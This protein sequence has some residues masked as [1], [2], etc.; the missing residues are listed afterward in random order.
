MIKTILRFLLVAYCPLLWAQHQTATLTEPH[1]NGMI[2]YEVAIREISLA[3]AALPTIHSFATGEVEGEWVILAGRTSGLHGMTGNNGFNPL[4]ENRDVWVINPETKQSWKKSLED[5]TASGLSQDEVDSLSCTNTEFYQDGETMI[6]VGGYGYMRSAAD[7]VTYDRISAINLP[8]LISWVKAPSGTE[9]TLAK[10]HIQQLIALYFQVTG[11][12]LEKIGD[13][14]QLVFGQ[15]YPGRYRPNFNGT[16]TRQVRRFQTTFAEGVF[17]VPS[18]SM[19]ATTPS[20]DY[21]RRDLN[22]VTV[23]ERSGLNVFSEKALVLS[24]VFTPANGVWT[25]PVV[26]GAGG[27]VS[28]S[29]TAAATSLRQGFQVYHSAK[30]TLFD[31]GSG[32]SHTLLFGGLTV[33]ELDPVS[34]TYVR[35]DQVPFTNQCSLVVRDPGGLISQYWLPTR[36]PAILEA[37][38]ELRFGTNAE[39]YPAPGV[40]KLPPRVI[41]LTAIA[42]PTVIGHIFGGLIADAGNG[43][44]T[45]ASG[46]VFEVVL[47]PTASDPDLRISQNPLPQLTWTYEA[48]HKD[49]IETSPDLETWS[50]FALPPAGTSSLVITPDA[51]KA[52]YR[53]HSSVVTSP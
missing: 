30:C 53:R 10:D 32:E 31:R 14:Y 3:P 5:P 34:E 48:D 52:F 45:G 19:L 9:T 7:H 46:R 43:G 36:F 40:A 20:D 38:K 15:N 41:D 12:A 24:G 28:M 18:A 23:L 16:Y 35:D 33:L 11:G 50:E 4:Y 44:N 39:F 22:V 37:G 1:L 47:T 13:E 2:P 6:V 17:S 42:S 49:L 21:R 25:A 26:I 8:G 51:G 29:D 27:D